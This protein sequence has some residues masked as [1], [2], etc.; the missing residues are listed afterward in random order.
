LRERRKIYIERERERER[1]EGWRKRV[2]IRGGESI[3]ES[4][5]GKYK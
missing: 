4:G 2:S 5:L 3:A 1:G